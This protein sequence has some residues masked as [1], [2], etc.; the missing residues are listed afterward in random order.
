[1]ESHPHDTPSPQSVHSLCH[2]DRSGRRGWRGDA[3][4]RLGA[5]CLEG[6][7]WTW[8][9]AAFIVKCNP[10][11]DG[12]INKL[13]YSCKFFLVSAMVYLCARALP[14]VPKKALLASSPSLLVPAWW[15]CPALALDNSNHLFGSWSC[16]THETFQGCVSPADRPPSGVPKQ[17]HIGTHKLMDEEHTGASQN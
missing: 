14:V 11:Y 15:R 8:T 13:K 5:V 2:R 9:L 16:N 3:L 7:Y 17:Q 12:L 10:A 1:M 4:R 6:G